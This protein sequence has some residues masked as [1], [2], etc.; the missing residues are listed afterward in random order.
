MPR[1]SIVVKEYR[2]LTRHQMYV[3]AAKLHSDNG[4]CWWI[5]RKIQERLALDEAEK[6]KICQIRKQRAENK[7]KEKQTKT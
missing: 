4:R 5:A 3:K 1:T 2:G 7:R 6:R